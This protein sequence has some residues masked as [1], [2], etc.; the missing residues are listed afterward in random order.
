MYI[1]LYWF[2]NSIYDYYVVRRLFYLKKKMVIFIH[3]VD[4]DEIGHIYGFK[5]WEYYNKLEQT[6]LYISLIV[7]EIYKYIENPLII[8]TTD[9]GGVGNSHDGA[10]EEEKN[11]FI[12]SNH[13]LN[14]FTLI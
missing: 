14:N 1:N 9:H 4:L 11:V 7:K 13:D 8:I 5:S 3:L 10:S 6:D 2:N 12:G